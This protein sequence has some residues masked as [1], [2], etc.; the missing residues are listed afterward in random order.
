M[1]K[2]ARATIGIM[3]VT[4]MSKVLGFLRELVLASVYGTSA[5]SDAYLVSL[6]IPIVIFTAIGTAISTTFIPLYYENYNSKGRNIAIRYTNNVLTIVTIICIIVTIVSV[7]FVEDIVKIFAMGFEG[8]TLNITI[9][10]TR[11]LLFGIIFISISEVIKG[12]LNAN[13]NFTVPAFML[14]IP[15]NIIIIII[16]SIVISAKINPNILAIGTL[17][18]LISK[19]I[20]QVPYMYKYGYK[21][22]YTFDLK[23]DSIKR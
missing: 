10:F 23:D 3:L 8:E 5:Y 14:G 13:N 18:G 1:N 19:V 9:N 6:N 22:K 11:I 12:Y 16:I 4:L 2:V 15:V 17:I 20:F 7:I 21:Y